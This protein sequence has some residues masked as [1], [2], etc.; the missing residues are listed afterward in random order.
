MVVD[1]VLIA[2]RLCIACYL[3]AIIL[4]EDS[5]PK[6]I[7]LILSWLLVQEK[8]NNF[9]VKCLAYLCG[10]RLYSMAVLSH[11]RRDLWPESF[12]F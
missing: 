7:F 6:R 11:S 1:L 4:E 5:R 2:S 9:L 3:T 12:R 8:R 10:K